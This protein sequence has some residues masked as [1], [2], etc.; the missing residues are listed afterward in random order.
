VPLSGAV[1]LEKEKE[2]VGSRI[3]EIEKYLFT[4]DKKL[5]NSSFLS[6][7]PEKVIAKE[8]AKK[9]KYEK[10]LDTLKE[11]LSALK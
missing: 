9:E 5:S 3:E 1:D 11:N 4:V 8:R 10:K 7:A 6:N 2:R